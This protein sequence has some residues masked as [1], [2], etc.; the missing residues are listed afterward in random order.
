MWH[1]WGRGREGI[2]V[3][4]G[5]KHEHWWDEI[6]RNSRIL[7]NVRLRLETSTP[8]NAINSNC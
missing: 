5:E 1:V 6:V 8:F 4:V 2:G 7:L 3:G